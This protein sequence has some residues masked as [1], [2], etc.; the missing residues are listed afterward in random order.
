MLS[1]TEHKVPSVKIFYQLS[2]WLKKMDKKTN[3]KNN[4]NYIFSGNDC[5]SNLPEP[6][7]LLEEISQLQVLI[8]FNK[9]FY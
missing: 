7:E 4:N 6:I 3:D 1:G 5:S 9:I 2:F 8:N